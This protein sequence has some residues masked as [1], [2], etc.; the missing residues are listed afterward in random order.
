MRCK[1]GDLAVTLGMRDP[2]NNGRLVEILRRYIDGEILPGHSFAYKNGG[3]GW[4]CRS[5]G[6]ALSTL[7]DGNQDIRTIN[8][9]SL[10]PIRDNPGEDEILRLVGKPER[11][12]A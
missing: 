5:L 3:D 4:V 2:A 12:S 7:L 11:K 8:D 9:S 6:M 10:R 1:V